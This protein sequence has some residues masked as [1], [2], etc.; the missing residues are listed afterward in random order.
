MDVVRTTGS[1]NVSAERKN[2]IIAIY[3]AGLKQGEITR[4]YGMPRDTV[5]SIIRRSK[6]C[7]SH[8]NSITIERRPKLMPGQ[9]VHLLD[10]VQLHK[11]ESFYAIIQR[12]RIP[13]CDKL[14][15]ST[16][17]RLLNINGIRS[18]VAAVKLY[19]STKQVPARLHW[20]TE[21]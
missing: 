11:K 3:Q 17:K 21:K 7:S 4:Y 9:H 6:R 16:T 2:K 15:E 10:Y 19:S 1:K 13:N 14:L 12:Y 5:K 18:Y 20:C 8:T